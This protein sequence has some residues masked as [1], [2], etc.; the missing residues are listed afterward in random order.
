MKH[1]DNPTSI[2][3]RWPI[4]SHSAILVSA[5]VLASGLAMAQGSNLQTSGS[6][7][8]DEVMYSI[9]GGNAVSMSHA[10]GMRSIGVGVGW[11]SNLICGDMSISTTIRNQLNGLTNGF[12][13][14]MS[15]VIQSATS[16]VAS[17]PA[18]IIQRADPGLY[19]LL[20][21]G[22]LQARLDYDR[23]KLRAYA[24]AGVQEITHYT[25][26]VPTVT[27]ETVVWNGSAPSGPNFTLTPGSFLWIKFADSRVLDLGH[28]LAGPVNLAAGVNVLSYAGF[29]SQ[30]S[31][32]KLLTQ[33]GMINARAVRMLDSQSGR[34]L[35]AEIHNGRPIGV[36][37]TVP[38]VA[39]VMLDLANA[40]NNFQPQ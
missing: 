40:V 4:R 12:Q 22:V 3:R 26:L 18:L 27:S 37:F 29:P 15:S 2:L 30:Y 33:L 13:N 10:A 17:L 8:G 11:N 16:A 34:W 39:V 5:L 14:I 36:D 35:V 32:Y 38:R 31:A 24:Q 6:V 9:G 21:N 19:N 23:S 1:P 28:D 25:A 20:T 7:I